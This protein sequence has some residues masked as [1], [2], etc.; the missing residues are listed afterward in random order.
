M[1]FLH[2][3]KINGFPMAKSK[4]LSIITTAAKK[5][6]RAHPSMKW[7]SAIKQA[8]ASYRA[9]HKAPAKKTKHAKVK[10]IAK[11]SKR[12]VGIVMNEGAARRTFAGG[13]VSSLK[14]QLKTTYLDKLGKLEGRKFL[15]TTKT[16]KRKI[17]KEI[18]ATKAELR[19]V[20]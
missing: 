3:E 12:K 19:K 8:S 13:T 10:R 16:G 17:A 7:V 5:L 1:Q 14:S 11:K 18:A 20:C 15:Q 4:A 2:Y 9:G 6:R